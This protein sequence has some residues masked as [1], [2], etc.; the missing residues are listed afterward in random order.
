MNPIR[1]TVLFLAV[2]LMSV[3]PTSAQTVQSIPFDSPRWDI[4]GDDHSLVLYKGKEAL[5]L[6]GAAAWLEDVAFETGTFE[7]D[8]AFPA[9][10]GFQGVRWQV[11]DRANFEEFYFRSHLSDMPDANQYNPVLGGYAAWQL[12]FGPEYSVPLHYDGEWKHVRIVVDEAG[13]EIYVDSVEPVLRFVKKGD[14]DAGGFGVYASRLNVAYFANFAFRPGTETLRGEPVAFAETE[15]GTV[16]RW[17]TAG[18]WGEAWEG[19]GAYEFSSEGLDW[20]S[21]EAEEKGIT[22]LARTI[23]GAER[24]HAAARVTIDAEKAGW[25]SV[26]FGYS[27]R[28]TVYLNGRQLYRGDNTWTSRDYR[29]LGTI[30][31]FDEIPLWLEEGENELVFVVT[32][33][34]GGFGVMARFPDTDGLGF[35]DGVV[36]R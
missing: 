36:H 31:L 21:L 33:A 26:L 18:P 13:G 6:Q 28:V 24:T 27:D 8:M 25:K 12:Y 23:T 2:C 10:R 17:D 9:E 7:F 20:V 4:E 3:V 11:Q 34:F 22:N 15:P 32:E 5:R 14:F 30:G 29:Y 1:A 16:T 35:A 19:A